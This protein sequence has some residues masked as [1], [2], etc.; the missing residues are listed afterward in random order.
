MTKKQIQLSIAIPLLLVILSACTG[1]EAEIGTLHN[2]LT[3]KDRQPPILLSVEAISSTEIVCRFNEP[4]DCDDA[5][6]WSV[7]HGQ[8]IQY[9]ADGAET[10]IQC[11]QPIPKGDTVTIEGKVR[12]A[13]G[14]TTWFSTSCWGYNGNVP[15][16]LINEFTTKG[17][18]T[19]PDRTELLV[20]SDGDIAGATLSDG[21]EDLWNSKVIL[22]SR[23]VSKGDFIVIWWKGTP[24]ES[25]AVGEN[26]SRIYSYPADGEPGLP[27]NNGILVLTASPA[28][29]AKILDA[30]VYTNRTTTTFNGFGSRELLQKVMRIVES[31]YWK[32]STQTLD[33]DCGIDSTYST[34]TRSICRT[35]DGQDTD[36][37]D[38]WHVVPTRGATFGSEN[39][40]EKY[41][42]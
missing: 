6:P 41:L 29:Q 3:G 19:N 11:G 40:K 37:K 2:L 33:A 17:S 7:S 18:E 39:T 42:P 25:V 26:G 15:L 12:D 9:M 10:I 1:C 4:V 20:L 16:M 32:S 38:D 31:G 34:A 27:G 21:P 13:A 23:Q 24:K 30:V 5:F 8:E 36:S 28:P 35:P 22:P 14:N